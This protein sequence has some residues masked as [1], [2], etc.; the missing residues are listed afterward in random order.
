MMDRCWSRTEILRSN[1]SRI[2]GS[3]VWKPGDKHA[4]PTSWI[5][6]PSL[7]VNGVA[8]GRELRPVVIEVFVFRSN[9]LGLW[10]VLVWSEGE[11]GGSFFTTIF[12]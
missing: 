11:V 7:A 12:G 4:K 2:A 3:C 8:E 5:T 10:R 6:S 9:F 1:C